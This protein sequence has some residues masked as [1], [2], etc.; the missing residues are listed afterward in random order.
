[1][2]EPKKIVGF[3]D[4]QI[5]TL[6]NLHYH[7]CDDFQQKRNYSVCT[8]LVESI[9]AGK[10]QPEDTFGDCANAV[11]KGKCSAVQKMREEAELGHAIYYVAPP[12]NYNIDKPLAT[13]EWSMNN[14]NHSGGMKARKFVPTP[15]SEIPEGALKRNVSKKPANPYIKPQPVDTGDMASAINEEMRL[16]K[17]DEAMANY[18]KFAQALQTLREKLINDQSK[19]RE[20]LDKLRAMF[21]KAHPQPQLEQNPT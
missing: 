5:G 18:P 17:I 8:R 9:R 2:N 3:P 21:L 15:T 19:L 12:E 13:R 6:P 10:I 14:G 16:I 11:C 20:S 4:V 7:W 1:M